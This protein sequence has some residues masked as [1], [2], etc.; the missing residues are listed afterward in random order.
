MGVVPFPLC[1][2][3]AHHPEEVKQ[4]MG[5][6]PPSAEMTGCS[7]VC[8]HPMRPAAQATGGSDFRFG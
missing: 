2:S 5:L 1:P 7:N 8:G 4:G 3:R 6:P